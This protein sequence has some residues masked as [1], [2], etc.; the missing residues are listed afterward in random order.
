MQV[1]MI[2]GLRFWP[3]AHAYQAGIIG[4][5]SYTYAVQV[6]AVWLQD[7]VMDHGAERGQCRSSKEDQ[8][9][10]SFHQHCP[11]TY[12]PTP[13][14]YAL[15]HSSLHAHLIHSVSPGEER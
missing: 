15:L 14:Q 3:V 13:S 10:R 11:K 1:R 2:E 4:M 8:K 7:R 5:A 6:G 12:A 9:P